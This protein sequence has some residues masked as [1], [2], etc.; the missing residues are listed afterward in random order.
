M[1]LYAGVTVEQPRGH[2]G[3]I[4]TNDAD[5]TARIALPRHIAPCELLSDVRLGAQETAA[6]KR[7]TLSKI[8]VGFIPTGVLGVLRLTIDVLLFRR[9]AYPVSRCH[10]VT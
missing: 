8:E 9:M 10:Y 2:D 6:K 7:R 4:L 3:A 5:N 1:V